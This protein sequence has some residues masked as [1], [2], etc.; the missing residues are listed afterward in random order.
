LFFSLLH[1]FSFYAAAPVPGFK[2]EDSNLITN[3]IN[4][5]APMPNKLIFIDSQSSLLPG[6]VANFK[7]LAH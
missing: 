2:T 3:P 6:F 4:P 1:E 5:T 7:V